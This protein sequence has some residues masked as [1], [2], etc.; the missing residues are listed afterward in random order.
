MATDM[1]PF[2]H[3]SPA[4]TPTHFRPGPSGATRTWPEMCGSGCWTG[5]RERQHI[6]CHATIARTWILT[7]RE[8]AGFEAAV[9]TVAPKPYARATATSFL[10]RCATT[11]SGCVARG[12]PSPTLKIFGAMGT[13]AG[14]VSSGYPSVE[15]KNPR[16]TRD[17]Y[18]IDIAMPRSIVARHVPAHDQTP[19]RRRHRG[20]LLPA[21]R[22]QLGRR[23]R[24]RGREGD[25]QLRARG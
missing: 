8:N 5:M 25:L 13:G 10:R 7:L 18:L 17:P 3:T 19:Q 24:L 12:R 23:A 4:P 1:L 2:P 9:S 15:P 6:R 22:E 20:P 14:G 16:H 21:R 11:S